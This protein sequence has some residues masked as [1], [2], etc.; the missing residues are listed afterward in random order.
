MRCAVS[1]ILAAM[2][3]GT[4]KTY[5]PI[6]QTGL[7]LDDGGADVPFGPD[8]LAESIFIMLRQGQRVVYDRIDKDGTEMATRFRL[9]EAGN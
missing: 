2:A 6:T 7:I 8:A 5:D 9:G 1:P 4:V 3:Q